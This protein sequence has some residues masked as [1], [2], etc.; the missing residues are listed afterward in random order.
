MKNG[1]FQVGIVGAGGIAVARHIPGWKALADVEVSAIADVSPQAGEQAAK[2]SGAARVFADYRQLTALDDL[3]IVDVCTPNAFHHPVTMAAL[4]AGKHVLCEK[5]LSVTVKE[6][7]EMLAASRKAGKKL[8]TAQHQRFRA[9]S[10][11]TKRLIDDGAFGEIYFASARAM[12][13]RGV[14]NRPTFIKKELSGGGPMLD[15]GVHILDLT[16]WFMGCPKVHSVTGVTFQKLAK[17]SE[18]GAG[19][20][21][22]DQAA[23]NVEDFAAGMI[24]FADGRALSL[25]CSFLVNQEPVEDF[26][27]D[28]F[29]TGAGMRWPALKMFTEK[30]GIVQDVALAA[31]PGPQ[32]VP[33]HEEIRLFME[34]VRSGGEVPV[35][36]ED[37]LEVIKMLEGMYRSSDTGREEVF[38]G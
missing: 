6:A 16:Y 19:K 8:M 37:S 30:F 3:D 4:A 25:T 1:R 28:I 9:D 17:T 18:Y 10:V 36:P 34:A 13:R 38:A 15:I 29:G 26:S 24:R 14:P 31:P 7:G 2:E 23:Y 21:G 5:P 22:W 32:T 20:S 27:T 11:L 33:H 35:R 12:R